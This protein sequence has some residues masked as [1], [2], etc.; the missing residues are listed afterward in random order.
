M[1]IDGNKCTDYIFIGHGL[2]GKEKKEAEEK[3][4]IYRTKYHIEKYNDLQLL[5]HKIFLEVYIDNLK[6]KITELNKSENIK[7]S[8]LIPKHIFENITSTL[9][10][11]SKIDDKLG[12]KQ[13]KEVNDFYNLF[14]TLKTKFKKWKEENQ[15]SRTRFCP[16]CKNAILFTMRME[17]YDAQVH[18]F[19]KDKILCNR[20]LWDLYKNKIITKQ[21]IAN[22]LGVSEF[23]IDWLEKKLYAND[24]KDF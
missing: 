13:E 15:L 20:P 9:E 8:E 14:E 2:K 7:D 23:Y 24:R 1:S 16:H 3:F 19:I 18:P 6:K 4:N 12:L 17:A 22:V 21:H 11:I 5:E 10:E